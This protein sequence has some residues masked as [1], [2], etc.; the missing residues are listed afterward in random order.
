MTVSE[1]KLLLPAVAGIL[2][3]MSAC[4]SL[5]DV[6]DATGLALANGG[7]TTYRIVVSEKAD[8]STKAVADDMAA[9][10]EQI[11][12]AVFPVVADTEPLLPNEIVVGH[13]NARLAAL[14][15]DGMTE[16]FAIDEYEIRTKGAHLVI[17][18]AP[19]RGSIN[20][21][22]GFLQD[23]LGCRWFTPGASRIPKDADL[24]IGRI[25][26]RQKPAFLWRM[27]GGAGYWD[28]DWV[29]RSRLNRSGAG[30]D[31]SAMGGSDPRLYTMLSPYGGHGL[32]YIPA[33]L[34][35]DHPEY[36]AE[37]DGKRSLHEV[38]G[39]RAYCISNPGFARYIAAMSTSSIR[40]QM[41]HGRSGYVPIIN[42]GHTDNHNYCKC[43]RCKASYERLGEGDVN[44]GIAGT[45]H[46]FYNRVAEEIAK[47]IPDFVIDIIAY[48]I[49]GRP[50]RVRMHPNIQVTW[51]PIGACQAH[52][53]DDCDANRDN[54]MLGTLDKWLARADRVQTWYYH[55][56][57]S[58]WMPHMKLLTTQRD[59]REFRRRGVQSMFVQSADIGQRTNPAP[60]GDKLLGGFGSQH[61]EYGTVPQNL[62][63][64]ISYLNIQ[65]M[66][67][68]D[69]DVRQG[70]TEFC[71]TY[72]GPASSETERIVLLLQ[73]IRSYERTMGTT[74]SSYPGVH[75]ANG[76]SAMLKLS[77]VT[78]MDTLFDDAETKVA[79]DLVLLRRVRMLRLTHQMGILCY[80]PADY[81]L[82]KKAFDAFFPLVEALGI[83]RFRRTGISE[84]V[85]PAEFKALVID[86][87]RIVISGQ[88]KAGDNLLRNSGFEVSSLGYGVPDGW[89]GTGL[90]MPEEYELDASG[91][92]V[93][94]TRAYAGESSVRLTKT[95]SGGKT[96]CLRQ[97]FDAQKGSRYRMNIRYLADVKTGGFYVIFTGLDKEGKFLR[98]YAGTRGVKNTAGEWYSLQVDTSIQDDTAFL[99]VEALLYD[100]KAEGMAWIDDFTCSM[101]EE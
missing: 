59:F 72:Y 38:A 4:A 90:Y 40:H 68:P 56:H 55:Y 98:H 20:G 48:T 99:L 7:S 29:A 64:L 47:E 8:V 77:V 34:Y 49:V 19:P 92:K 83:K 37:I 1:S 53:F 80:A 50:S 93:D 36:Y 12:G 6:T 65:L 60:D 58:A 30:A 45:Y 85:T 17:A 26:D 67:N 62:T 18:G 35:D 100:D 3:L 81:P 84:R 91:I 71:E 89:S 16:G 61:N 96:V 88:E 54:D 94:T 44:V 76:T 43:A 2:T 23:H 15:L 13:D 70:I 27:A 32:N 21:M 73:S 31:H 41:T 25:V 78:E 74:F 82:R 57:S 63:H 10:L 33:S 14:A 95:P 69:F 87:D 51:C 22:Y 66:W 97:R 46:E 9:I 42:L 5:E 11:T 52:A 86:P 39:Q 75:Q 79:G 28:P 24:N 101:L